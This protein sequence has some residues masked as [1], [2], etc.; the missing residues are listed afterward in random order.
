MG[1]INYDRA[2]Q[3][4]RTFSAFCFILPYLEQGTSFASYNFSVG[5]LPSTG[6][7]S[8]QATAGRQ[9]ISAYFCPSDHTADPDPPGDI[10]VSQGSYA[11]SRGQQENIYFNWA[12][13]GPLPDPSGQYAGSCNF[14]G[15]DGMFMP[16]SVVR[17]AQVSDGTSNTFLI[18]EMSRFV[19]EPTGNNPY[20]FMN[21]TAAFQG[22]PFGAG[23]P[24]WPGDVRVTSGAFVIPKLNSPADKTGDVINAC[25]Q[26]CAYPPDWY[27][28]N[29][30]ACRNLGQWGFRSAHPG[31]AN[32]ALADG[33]VR[34]VK[35]SIDHNSYRAL[36][37]RAGGEIVGG[38]AF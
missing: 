38:D 34:F 1:N 18:G 21:Y 6:Q 22:P 24:T 12:N 37:T 13:V 10:E 33:S 20:N 31:G 9:Q 30:A 29:L 27:R 11:M 3:Q 8:A 5:N 16:E 7:V 25:F 26:N 2:C 23:A 4:Q 19:D 28:L 14:G 17:I 36:G 35:N 15:G 32:F